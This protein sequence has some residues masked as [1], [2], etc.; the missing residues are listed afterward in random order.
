MQLRHNRPDFDAD[1]TYCIIQKNEKK[2]M[3]NTYSSNKKVYKSIINCI[4]QNGTISFSC[5]NKYLTNFVIRL[6]FVFSRSVVCS[7]D[8]V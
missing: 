8:N 2:C 1:I 3:N 5:K 7:C 6:L 4:S